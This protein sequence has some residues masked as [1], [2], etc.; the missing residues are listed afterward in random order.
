MMLP[1]QAM[2][3]AIDCASRGQVEEGRLWLGI[4]REM[5]EDY[6]ARKSWETVAPEAPEPV[7][8]TRTLQQVRHDRTEVLRMPVER[9][10]DPIDAEATCAHC[11]YFV[12][13]DSIVGNEIDGAVA[14]YVHTRTGI[15]RC[16]VRTPAA[17][18]TFIYTYAEPESGVRS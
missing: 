13:L 5:R 15:A 18:E 17:D 7:A 10:G 4:A 9:P 2:E 16:P 1:V 11:G 8:D 12:R 14:T 6:F 3:R